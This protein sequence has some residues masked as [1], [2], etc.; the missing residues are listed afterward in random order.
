[1]HGLGLQAS[2]LEKSFKCIIDRKV[3]TAEWRMTA[4]EVSDWIDTMAKRLRNLLHDTHVAATK[5]KTIPKWMLVLPWLKAMK[6]DEDEVDG[7]LVAA[8]KAHVRG[9]HIAH[10]AGLGSQ[11]FNRLGAEAGLTHC[12]YL[13]RLFQ[14][15]LH[16]STHPAGR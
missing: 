5:K 11:T 16:V 3:E 1:M 4:Q 2:T 6:C 14:K 7:L 9:K 12:E 15:L 10:L 13:E 8:S